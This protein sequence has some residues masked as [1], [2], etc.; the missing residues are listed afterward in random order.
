MSWVPRVFFYENFLSDEECAHFIA[1]GLANG[2]ERS[3]VAI[4]KSKTGEA[5]EART[6]FGTF[7]MDDSDEIVRGV[8]SRIA[9]WTQLP[10]EHGEVGSPSSLLALACC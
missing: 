5:A 4:G 6:S 2:L 10:I 8:E 7:I 3:K 9:K 1:K